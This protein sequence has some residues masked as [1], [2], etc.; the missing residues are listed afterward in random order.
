MPARS[1]WKGFL[2]LSLVSVPVKAYTATA[3]GS[4]IRLNQ[5]HRECHSPI[6]YKKVCPIHGELSA[7][8]IISGYQYSKGQYVQIDTD[9]L[10]KLRPVS[11]KSFG[12]DGFIAE[13]EIDPI[14][15]QGRTY[16]L[17]PDGPVGQKPYALLRQGM[18]D[19][20][21]VA[22]V[23]G[24]ISGKEQVML[25]RPLDRLLA[26]TLLSLDSQIKKP[27]SFQDELIDAQH[28]EDELKLTETLI[29]ASTIEDFDFASY[30]N[31]YVENLTKLIE[32]KVDGKE[33]VSAPMAEEAQVINL[34]DALKQ[35]VQSL[36]GQAAST[37]A[38]GS[39]KKS[40]RKMA[41]S[42]TKKAA[43]RARKKSG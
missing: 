37:P 10:G 18:E 20:G 41:P 13:G 26:L 1:S 3:S 29:D 31:V 4:E 2:K 9:E 19:R 8:D 11:D 32:L 39:G 6:K 35:S 14:Y 17:V 27:E 12:I 15:Y 30:K 5:L 36:T 38:S 7:E 34:M 33:V 21:L 16:Y 23:Q 43:K 40:K 24:V 25:L 28:T 22:I 42:K